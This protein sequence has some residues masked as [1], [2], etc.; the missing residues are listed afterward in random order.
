[1]P[2]I[3]ANEG[4]M[5]WPTLRESGRIDGAVQIGAR[6]YRR[7]DRTA[8]LADQRWTLEL[9]LYPGDRTTLAARFAPVDGSGRR[10]PPGSYDL[11]LGVVRETVGWL[12]EPPDH[13]VVVAVDVR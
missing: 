9:G 10:F 2:L 5:P 4:A 3:V 1:M 6:W 7:G 12:P 13:A 8:V 11:E